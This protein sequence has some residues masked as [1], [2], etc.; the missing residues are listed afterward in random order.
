V[1]RNLKERDNLEGPGI[2]ERIELKL[3]LNRIGGCGLNL[4]TPR[5]FLGDVRVVGGVLLEELVL[6]I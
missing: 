6:K 5:D 4:S 3:T 1:V 2:D